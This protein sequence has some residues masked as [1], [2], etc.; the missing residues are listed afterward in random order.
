MEIYTNVGGRPGIDCGGFCEFCFYKGVD[1]TKLDPFGC[2]NCSPNQVGCEYCLGLVNRA[3]NSFKPLLNVFA[4]LEKQ[5]IQYKMLNSLKE[6]YKIRINAG[7][8]IFNYPQL[9]QLVSTI[10][11]SDLYLHLGYT[12]GKP[13]NNANMAENLIST[14]LDEL[15]FSVFS[16][17][18]EIRRKWMNDEKPEE[19]I[20]GLKLF[21]ENIPVNASAIVIPGINDKDKI[22]QTCN[23]LEEWGVKSLTLRR[24]AN[25][26]NQ[27]LIFNDNPVIDKINPHSYKEYNELVRRISDEYPFQVFSFPF[28]DHKKDFPFAISKMKNRNHLEKLSLITS[29]AS[30]L[31]SKL[32][33]PFLKKIFGIIDELNLVNIVTLDK[34]IADL[35]IKEDLESVNI[36]ELKR[37]V[38]IPGGALVHDKEVREILCKDGVSRKIIRG[39]QVLTHPYYERIEFNQE[40]LINYELKSFN[41]LIDKINLQ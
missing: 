24:F 35:I 5:F 40:E 8:D 2:K 10:K 11:E 25:F 26:K 3:K 18:P 36:N 27:G 13:I 17:N 12:S 20:K 30:I 31:T 41:D 6:D 28:F 23:D 22:F 38:I 1:L 37:K 33:T 14:G 7:S 32:A 16:T 29:E 15:S 19:S 39:P 9:N 34:D 4:D 21:C